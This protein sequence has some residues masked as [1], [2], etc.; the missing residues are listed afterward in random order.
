MKVVDLTAPRQALRVRIDPSPA[1]DFLACLYL[2]GA[3][4][5]RFGYEVPAAWVARA[6]QRLGREL[7]ADLALLFPPRGRTLG[8]VGVLDGTTGASV[9]AFIGRVAATPAAALLELML[10]Q[11]LAHPR[12][13]PRL[14]AAIGGGRRAVEALLDAVHP[15]VDRRRVRRLLLLAP[16]EVQAR[17]V[18]V[19]REGYARVYA[20][21]APTVVSLLA[22]NAAQLARQA[23][24]LPP[25]A[26]VERATGGFVIGPDAALDAVVLA[27]TYYFRP[28]N[29]ITAYRQVRVFIYPIELPAAREGPPPDLVRVYK[30]LGDETRLRILRLLAQREMYLQ[31]VARALRVSHVTALHHLALLRAAHLVRVVDRGALKYYRLRPDRL[32][33]AADQGLAF[34]T[35]APAASGEGGYDGH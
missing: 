5:P 14:R 21:E 30:A 24:A 18:R 32:R 3:Y 16:E 34:L 35:A 33:E 9:E 8:V 25:A 2:V 17:L 29:L 11:T 23:A 26:L 7:R 19:L 10:A 15:D 28:Y 1:Y 27:P 20:P 22:R 31:E 6:R 12:D 13:L 4:D